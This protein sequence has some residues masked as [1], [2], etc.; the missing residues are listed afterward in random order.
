MNKMI[1]TL[2][3]LTPA[4]T[5]LIKKIRLINEKLDAV[6]K[7]PPELQKLGMAPTPPDAIMTMSTLSSSISSTDP[8]IHEKIIIQTGWHQV[9]YNTIMRRTKK[10]DSTRLRVLRIGEKVHLAERVGRRVRIDKP[11][12]GWCSF[13]SDKGEHILTP[14]PN[15]D[16][17]DIDINYNSKR[18][19]FRYNVGTK[20]HPIWKE[21]DDILTFYINTM[22][23]EYKKKKVTLPI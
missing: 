23:S 15:I 8:M 9:R 19:D 1:D 5:D 12:Q 6:S 20:K 17:S 21:F 22:Y 16:I 13:E 7:T 18:Y 11:F 14:L 10:L 3:S 4:E 2:E